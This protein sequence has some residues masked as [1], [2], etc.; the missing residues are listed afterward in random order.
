MNKEIQPTDMNSAIL[1][2]AIILRFKAHQQRNSHFAEELVNE[3]KNNE[4]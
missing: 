1:T 2:E 4:N 3:V